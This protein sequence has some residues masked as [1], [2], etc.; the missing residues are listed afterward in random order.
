MSYAVIRG[1]STMEDEGRSF[2]LGVYPT[3]AKAEAAKREAD[4]YYSHDIYKKMNKTSSKR[5]KGT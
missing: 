3:K 5:Y 2:L 4:G 1:P